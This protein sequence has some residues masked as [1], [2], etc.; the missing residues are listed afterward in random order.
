MHWT[1]PL[2]WARQAAILWALALCGP[3]ARAADADADALKSAFLYNFAQFVTWPAP[4][5]P[6]FNLCI[7]GPDRLAAADALAGKPVAQA[8]IRIVRS[9]PD[10]ALAA[11]HLLYLGAAPGEEIDA[12]LAA[13]GGAPVLTVGESPGATQR[14]VM[15]NLV[16]EGHRIQF[17]VNKETADRA[18]LRISA[19]LLRL[20]RRVY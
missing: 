20:A 10:G 9:P 16:M 4:P 11:C 14:G 3:A 17:D 1:R 12:M 18:G 15:I 7:R 13:L 19:P 6:A 2:R 5:G 8:R